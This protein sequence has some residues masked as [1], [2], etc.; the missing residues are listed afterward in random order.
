MRWP[1][2]LQ[3]AGV[4]AIFLTGWQARKVFDARTWRRR[5]WNP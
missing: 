3:I 4:V 5:T 1:E 2:I